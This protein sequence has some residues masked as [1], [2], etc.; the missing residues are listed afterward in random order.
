MTKLTVTVNGVER[1]LVFKDKGEE[2]LATY[3]QAPADTIPESEAIAHSLRKWEGLKP[4]V[5]S[6]YGLRPTARGIRLDHKL[7]LEV[8]SSTCALCELYYDP[9][10]ENDENVERCSSCPL[11]KAR[12]GVPCDS[13]YGDEDGSPYNLWR[14]YYDPSLMITWLEKA[15]AAQLQGPTNATP[16]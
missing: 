14:E 16:D 8:N 11:A 3:Y 7:L 12:D 6:A 15:L 10:E 9:D 5:L 1:P 2:W 4:E 13:S